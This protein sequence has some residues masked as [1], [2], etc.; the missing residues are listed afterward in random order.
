MFWVGVAI[1]GVQNDAKTKKWIA[2][3]RK[4]I[5]VFIMTE[6]MTTAFF[7]KYI[8]IYYMIFYNENNFIKST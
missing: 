3:V 5:S 1:L 8:P 2:H 7:E 6:I 4:N